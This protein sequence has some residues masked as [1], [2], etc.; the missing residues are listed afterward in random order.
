M[1]GQ[2]ELLEEEALARHGLTMT[3]L[4][5]QGAFGRVMLAQS[6]PPGQ[7]TQAVKIIQKHTIQQQEY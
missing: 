2:Y 4:L 5:G 6:I 1:Q 7:R 3:R